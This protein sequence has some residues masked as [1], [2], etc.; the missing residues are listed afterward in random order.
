MRS[1]NKRIIQLICNINFLGNN[2]KV[3]LSEVKFAVQAEMV[4][5]CCLSFLNH[6]IIM[7]VY[8]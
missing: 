6:N 1:V 3:W 5:I 4:I 8:M 7:S 2:F